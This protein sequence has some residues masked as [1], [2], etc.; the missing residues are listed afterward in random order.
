M[1]KGSNP[2]KEKAG[3]GSAALEIDD[4]GGR[5]EDVEVL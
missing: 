2:P 4:E 1:K 5:Q 3:T